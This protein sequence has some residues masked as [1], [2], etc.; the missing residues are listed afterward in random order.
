MNQASAKKIAI[1]IGVYCLII[2][3]TYF[4]WG[5][6]AF[7]SMVMSTSLISLI[8]GFIGFILLFPQ[9]TRSTGATIFISSFL[10]LVIGFSVCSSSI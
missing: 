6:D 1:I 5:K 9:N 2:L 8:T 10:I 4:I 7:Q 3:L